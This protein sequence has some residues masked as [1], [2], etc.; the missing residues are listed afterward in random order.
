ML[1]VHVDLDHLRGKE[2]IS[3]N[4]ERFEQSEQHSTYV[5]DLQKFR[6][7]TQSHW[8][9]PS[10]A[11]KL[12]LHEALRRGCHVFSS[13]NTQRT[14]SKHL[15]GGLSPDGATKVSLC[16]LPWN[17]LA[18][19]DVADNWVTCWSQIT[20]WWSARKEAEGPSTRSWGDCKPLDGEPGPDSEREVPGA[21][22]PATQATVAS[23]GCGW[24]FLR[25]QY[26]QRVKTAKRV[27]WHLRNKLYIKYMKREFLE[28][29]K[30]K[31]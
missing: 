13:E 16:L 15:K 26:L 12:C 3:F 2:V 21:A 24:I 8:H 27:S 18:A 20:C 22:D 11:G 29:S 6:I 17:A 4:V 10:I 31:T 30:K 5:W 23:P 9:V 7:K 19:A 25:L 1:R 14:C 28:T